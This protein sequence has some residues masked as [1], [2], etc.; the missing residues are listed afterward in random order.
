MHDRANC[1]PRLWPCVVTFGGACP[2]MQV[3]FG[4]QKLLGHSP[5]MQLNQAPGHLPGSGC[6]PGTL[7]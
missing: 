6:L 3:P 4:V 1:R 5:F 2:S 7:Q